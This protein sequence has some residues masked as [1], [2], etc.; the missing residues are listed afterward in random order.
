MIVAEPGSTPFSVALAACPPA[1]MVTGELATATLPGVLET[2]VNETPPAG[3][4]AGS[5]IGSDAVW[6]YGTFSVTGTLMFRFW[7]A[8]SRVPLV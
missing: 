3:A 7:T 2:T 4:G 5:W 6:P 8:T 1:A